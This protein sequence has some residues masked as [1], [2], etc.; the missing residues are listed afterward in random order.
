[1]QT[2]YSSKRNSSHSFQKQDLSFVLPYQTNINVPFCSIVQYILNIRY[3]IDT[4]IQVQKEL[5]GRE[6]N[7]HLHIYMYADVTLSLWYTRPCERHAACAKAK[8]LS[9][10]RWLIEA[11]LIPGSD[12]DNKNIYIIYTHT[13][14]HIHTTHTIMPLHDGHLVVT[15]SIH[16]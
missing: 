12:Q 11:A 16:F 1:M 7:T 5:G 13:H 14:I 6:H 3:A 10:H 15:A 8:K 2:S 4:Y 9:S